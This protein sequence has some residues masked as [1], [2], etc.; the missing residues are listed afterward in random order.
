MQNAN[1]DFELDPSLIAQRPLKRRDGAK[2]MVLSRFGNE[3]QNRYFH[4][5][6]GLLAPGDL[7]VVNDT[8]VIPARILARKRGT[9]GRLQ[10]LMI[11]P[12]GSGIWEALVSAKVRPGQD[13]IVEDGSMGRVMDAP[14]QGRVRV[15]FELN[16]PF[17]KWLDA[18]GKTPLPPYIKRP[19][20]AGEADDLEDRLSYQ[21]VYATASGS[22]AAPTAGLHFTGKLLDRLRSK[23]VQIASVTLHIGPGTFRPLKPDTEP[24]PPDREYLRIP[25]GTARSILAAKQRGRRIIA[26][27]TSTARALESAADAIAHGE[28]AEGET[29]LFIQPGFRFRIVDGLITNFHLPGS[30]LLLLTSAFAGAECLS[31]AYREAMARGYRFYSFGDAMLIR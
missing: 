20:A 21:T 4:E 27:G 10:L 11:K 29:G 24:A 9:G 2:L 22:I 15:M 1:F 25:G 26:V 14:V 28:G 30:S 16:G 31:K 23:G 18:V 17:E 3:I 6:P 8:R 12:V 13:L 19:H 7:V 5:L